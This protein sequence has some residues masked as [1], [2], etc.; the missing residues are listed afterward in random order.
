MGFPHLHGIKG[1]YL[2]QKVRVWATILG[3]ERWA[4][5][6]RPQTA[7]PSTRAPGRSHSLP[8]PYL[9]YSPSHPQGCQPYA[10]S[11][12]MCWRSTALLEVTRKNARLLITCSVDCCNRHCAEENK[13]NEPKKSQVGLGTSCGPESLSQIPFPRH[14]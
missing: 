11:P 12:W 5:P 7:S 10:F 2:L 1:A 9:A 13:T 14:W 4:F 3:S 8:G 6:V